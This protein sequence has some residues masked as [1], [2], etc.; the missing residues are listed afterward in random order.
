MQYDFSRGTG[1]TTG[2]LIFTDRMLCHKQC[3]IGKDT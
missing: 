1:S 2:T 3:V